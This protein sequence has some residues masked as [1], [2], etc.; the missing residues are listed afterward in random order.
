MSLLDDNIT[1][2]VDLDEGTT[3]SFDATAG[4][5]A[6]CAH[7]TDW[8][9][10]QCGDHDDNDFSAAQM[11]CACGGGSRICPSSLNL[12]TSQGG[13]EPD[14]IAG[15]IPTAI[16]DFTSLTSIQYAQSVLSGT[17]PSQVGRLTGLVA[18]EI[19]GSRINTP[20]AYAYCQ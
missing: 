9:G 13:Y 8:G 12:A 7:Y 18:L 17:I 10:S 15:T 14:R 6:T 20:L 16:G 5:L 11:C 3:G 4:A 19:Q 1:C 2:C